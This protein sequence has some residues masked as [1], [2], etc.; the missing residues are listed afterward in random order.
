MK[1]RYISTALGIV[2]ATLLIA[3]TLC[4]TIG[5]KGVIITIGTI[6]AILVSMFLGAV[7][8]ICAEV[9]LDGREERFNDKK[10]KSS[11]DNDGRI[12]ERCP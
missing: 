11:N 7:S 4:L 1:T 12:Q 8:A 5:C 2:V 10:Q 3:L 9:A 6:C